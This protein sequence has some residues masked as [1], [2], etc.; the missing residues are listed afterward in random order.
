MRRS[1]LLLPVTNGP[2]VEG[3]R[4]RAAQPSPTASP[5]FP[6][7]GREPFSPH[8]QRHTR[9]QFHKKRK[10][11][12]SDSLSKQNN[13]IKIDRVRNLIVLY[14]SVQKKKE[15]RGRGSG[16]GK[17]KG[18]EEEETTKREERGLTRGKESRGNR[19]SLEN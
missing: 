16:S 3:R 19:Y 15:G 8:T 11:K 7:A 6:S 10:G 5:L 9:V 2:V 4:H 14:H 1:R 18:K 12:K 13:T 17:G